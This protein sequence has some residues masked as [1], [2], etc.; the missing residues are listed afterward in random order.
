[1]FNV[2]SAVSCFFYVPEVSVIST[3]HYNKARNIGYFTCLLMY[4][5][6]APAEHAKPNLA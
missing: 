5:Y 1:M 4:S 6:Y 3:L 2:K